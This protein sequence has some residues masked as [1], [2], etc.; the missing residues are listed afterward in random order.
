MHAFG[1]VTLACRRLVARARW[2]YWLIVAGLAAV[3]ALVAMRAVHA[4]EV[5]AEAW[6]TPVAVV[7]AVDDVAAG[8]RLSG[9]IAVTDVPA[10]V[11]PA[12]AVRSIEQLPAAAVAVQRIG[13][14]EIV[15]A[16]D[17]V[18]AGAP[19]ALIPAGWLAVPILESA[20]SGAV[21]GDR[22]AVAADGA[23]VAR[24]GVV[25]AITPE[26]GV[27]V[28]ALPEE[29][30]A[31]AAEAAAARVAVVLLAPPPGSGASG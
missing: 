18:P 19:A 11:V 25:V 24:H 7:T 3:A 17:L 23:L 27:V 8:E 22:V 12:G 16:H 4:A 2:V 20:S 5:A 13:A 26:A 9:R 15:V 21:V 14:G 6:G 31:V 1:S 29:V 30:A 10:P 28:V